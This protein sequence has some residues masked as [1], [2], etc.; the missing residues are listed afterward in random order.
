MMHE[1]MESG[2]FPD[3]HVTLSPADAAAVDALLDP[4]QAGEAIDGER[5]QRVAAWLALLQSCP[6]P[7]PPGTLLART[8]ARVGQDAVPQAA[9]AVSSRLRDIF[10]TRRFAELSAIAATIAILL[11][12][13]IPTLS[14][15]RVEAQQTACAG[16]LHQFAEALSQYSADHARELPELASRGATWLPRPDV[17]PA[18]TPGDP[19]VPAADHSNNANLLPLVRGSYAKPELLPCPAAEVS[20]ARF[21]PSRAVDIPEGIRGYSYINLFGTIKPLWNA[22]AGVV[23]LSDRN[24]LFGTQA[25]DDIHANSP[26]HLGRGENLLL[27]DG[28]VRWTAAPDVALTAGT[29]DNIWT[30]CNFSAP[31]FSGTETTSSADDS[32]VS[33]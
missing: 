15:A 31:P 13:L 7:E 20:T 23:I 22:G 24:P 11:T 10:F 29:L 33:P 27:A 21:D 2:R 3:E 12:V 5:R 28:S 6:A 32:F 1:N 8:L 16:N 25:S 30:P 19:A 18:G 17:T 14:R 9:S 26:N 4:A